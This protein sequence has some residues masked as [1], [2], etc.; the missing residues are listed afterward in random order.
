MKTGVHRGRSMTL[1]AL[2]L[3]LVL[4]G[5][6]QAAATKPTVTTK[7]A[8]NVGQTTVQLNGSVNP[9]GAETR[10]FFQIGT[11]SLYGS[12]SPETAI[13]SGTKTVNVSAPVA[14]LTPATTY[15]YRIVAINS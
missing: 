15:H 12:N 5:T 10:Y 8:S 6:A 11:T 7:A 4:P 13:G 3:A 14:D 9:N 2:A 1:V